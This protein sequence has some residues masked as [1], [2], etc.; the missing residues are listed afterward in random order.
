MVLDKINQANDIKKID[1][2]DYTALAK[3]IR[4]W[5]GK[6][7]TWEGNVEAL[8]RFARQRNSY[9]IPDVQAFFGLSDQ[10]MRE[11]GFEV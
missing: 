11:Y 1:A 7:S 5:G 4:R 6:V 9:F 3:E 8:R 10:Q 2:E